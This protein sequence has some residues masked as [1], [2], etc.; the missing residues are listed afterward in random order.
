MQF[1]PPRQIPRNPVHKRQ[2]IW[3]IWLPLILVSLVFLGLCILAVFLT[4]NGSSVSSQWAALSVIMIL[5]PVCLGGFLVFLMIGVSIYL[6]TRILQGAPPILYKLQVILMRTSAVVR[7]YADRLASPVITAN[8][9]WAG[10]AA[11]FKF[12]RK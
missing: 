3:Q 1:Q 10:F 12:R 11:I 4:K 6:T 5:F 2:V 9:K 7:Y 8:E